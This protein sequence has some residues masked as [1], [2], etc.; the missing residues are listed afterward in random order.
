[1][2]NRTR[3]GTRFCARPRPGGGGPSP[4]TRRPAEV[5]TEAEVRV[6][7]AA[8]GDDAVGVRH[9][10]LLVMMYRAGLR[11][12]EA[13]ALRP[14]DV[15]LALSGWDSA[16]DSFLHAGGPN[17]SAPGQRVRSLGSSAVS[18]GRS[19]GVP[20]CAWLW[21]GLASHRGGGAGSQ[22]E[23]LARR[24][25]FQRSR[26]KVPASGRCGLPVGRSPTP[27][28]RGCETAHLQVWAAERPRRQ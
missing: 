15:D 27:C 16:S 23:P 8:C 26:R 6:L 14:H 28:L 7:L 2:W 12:S 1:M 4:G 9:R 22:P 25:D 20:L 21:P 19:G 3:A 5:L 11:I 10:A 18:A 17:T 13:L 24:P